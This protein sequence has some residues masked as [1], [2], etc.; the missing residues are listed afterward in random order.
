MDLG[1]VTAHDEARPGV[2]NAVLD[3]RLS[4]DAR[5]VAFSDLDRATGLRRLFLRAPGRGGDT[6]L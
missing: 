6:A 4:P 5:S 1:P 2:V 3:F